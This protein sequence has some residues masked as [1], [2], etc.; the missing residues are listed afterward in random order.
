ML[1][2][3][4]GKHSTLAFGI[5]SGIAIALILFLAISFTAHGNITILVGLGFIFDGL[6]A[7]LA[8]YAALF[9]ARRKWFIWAI[10]CFIIAMFFKL[11]SLL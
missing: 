4:I 2:K 10:E 6:A 11:L 8:L 5:V 1:L 9:G 3:G 7:A